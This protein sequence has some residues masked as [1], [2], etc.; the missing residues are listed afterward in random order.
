MDEFE[1]KKSLVWNKPFFELENKSFYPKIY[2]PNAVDEPIPVDFNGVLLTIDGRMKSSLDWKKEKALAANYIDKGLKIFWEI[3]LG[4]LS[5]LEYALDN[6]MQFQALVLALQHFKDTLWSPF[7]DHTLGLCLYRGS[8][9]FSL[10]YPWDSKQH[11]RYREWLEQANDTSCAR[12]FYCGQSAAS[13]LRI[14]SDHLTDDLPL[15]VLVDVKD[16]ENPFEIA[17]LISANLW[18]RIQPMIKGMEHPTPYFAWSEGSASSGFIGRS[19]PV[20]V[21][22]HAKVA[23]CLPPSERIFRQGEII[24]G[25]DLLHQKKISYKVIPESMLTV[26][27]DGLDYLLFSPEHLSK[28]GKRKLLGFCAAGGQVVSLGKS[29]DLP[30]EISLEKFLNNFKRTL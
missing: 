30:T 7:E 5:S 10:H 13:Y 26:E 6:E 28:E 17:H 21:E 16:L 18:G 19:V 24:S 15:F 22:N 23:L 3:N 11:L 25:L 12:R 8:A 14:L 20:I 29:A 2:L 9:D 27:W 4:L 1:P